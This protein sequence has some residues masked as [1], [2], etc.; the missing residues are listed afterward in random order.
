[1]SLEFRPPGGFGK[2]SLK[3]WVSHRFGQVGVAD[4][5]DG[6]PAESCWYFEQ[7]VTQQIPASDAGQWWTPELGE[8]HRDDVV[9]LG[10]DQQHHRSR[11]E[12]RSEVEATSSGKRSQLA[13]RDCRNVLVI[14][15]VRTVGDSF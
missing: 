15:N 12:R 8:H 6:G 4:L 2:R 14:D 11:P 9:G 1:M 13:R 10:I 7:I 3:H 5:H